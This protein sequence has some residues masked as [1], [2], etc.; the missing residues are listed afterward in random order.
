MCLFGD[1]SIDIYVSCASVGSGDCHSNDVKNRTQFL[2][3]FPASCKS[4]PG[5]AVEVTIVL[6]SYV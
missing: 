5:T 2:P 3:D 4:S 1:R 6:T